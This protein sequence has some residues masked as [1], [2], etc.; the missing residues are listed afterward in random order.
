MF[1]FINIL[2]LRQQTGVTSHWFWS[3]GKSSGKSKPTCFASAWMMIW[4]CLATS[5]KTKILPKWPLVPHNARNVCTFSFFHCVA[6]VHPVTKCHTHP[7]LC[8]GWHASPRCRDGARFPTTLQRHKSCKA[9]F[10]L[11]ETQRLAIPSWPMRAELVERSRQDV[12][13]GK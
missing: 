2:L 11:S 7:H 10:M 5:N 8:M 4:N 9:N 13:V 6:F 1:H 12:E 3:S